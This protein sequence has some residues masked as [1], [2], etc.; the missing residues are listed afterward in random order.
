MLAPVHVL[1][2]PTGGRGKAA[3]AS[4]TVFA[5][6]R[7]AGFEVVDISGS[8]AS[9]SEQAARDAVEA[10]A[11]RI[12]TVGGDGTLHLGVQ[13]VAGTDAILGVVPVGTGND[14][15][16]TFGLHELDVEEAT[17]RA[18][19]PSRRIDAIRA[20]PVDRWVAFNVT[21]GFTTDVNNRASRL[22]FPKGPS[23]Y[24]VAT[25]LTLPVLRHRDIVVTLDDTRIECTSAMI[26]VANTPT[27]GGGMAICPDATADDGML[28]VAIVGPTSRT[29]LLRLLPKV[30]N[31]GHVGH[32]MVEIVRGRE[33][34][35]AGEPMSLV[36]DGE[37][38][39]DSPV[40]L[41]V[42]PKAL[43]VAGI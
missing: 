13:G 8:T 25:L 36:A 37:D 40:K 11:T 2:S 18:L 22:R 16:R 31:G 12:V 21:G 14:F 26:A 24:T 3:A 17:R 33:V 42:V 4:K 20:T 15:A 10:G 23:R 34:T 32:P 27:F 5:V 19:G 30:F 39:C 1:V 28:D 7:E 9:K 35:I 41:E 38:L 43:R 6:I 29:T